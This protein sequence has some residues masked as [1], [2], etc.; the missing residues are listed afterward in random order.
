MR[1]FQNERNMYLRKLIII[2]AL[3]A[4]F[5]ILFYQVGIGVNLLLYNLLLL[6]GLAYV[7]KLALKGEVNLTLI[8]GTLLSAIFVVINGSIFAIA[9]NIISLFLLAG[10]TLFPIS[11]S[12]I[13]TSLISIVNFFYSQFA[14]L[15][16]IGELSKKSRYANAIVKVIRIL[17][18]PLIVLT[19]FILI[20]RAANPIFE[21]MLKSIFDAVENF[22]NWIFENFE[23]ALIGTIVF[24]FIIS[25]YFIL[26]K[27]NSELVKLDTGSS[28]DLTQ[29]TLSNDA[30]ITV[31]TEYKSAIVLFAMLNIL[32]LIINVIDIRWVWFNFSWD[33]EYLK[34]FVHEGTYLLILSI[35]ISLALS[36]YYFR[37]SVNFLE[38]NRNLRWLAYLWLFQNSILTVSVGIRNFWY[39]NYFSLAYLRIG[40]IFFLILTLYS[41]YTV[42]VKVR[43]KK[44]TYFL[45]SKNSLA[46]Y[47][48]LV[49]MA[50]FNWDVIIAKYNFSHS[51]SA[52]IHFNFLSELGDNALPYLDKSHDELASI[53]ANQKDVFAFR[54]Q[55][56]SSREYYDI[57]QER[58]DNFL[59]E[60]EKSKWQDWN[61]A[62]HR[63]YLKLKEQ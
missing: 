57:I 28:N 24:G 11:R 5:T 40:V 58:K 27:P 25:N 31:K 38:K 52:F 15:G 61:L 12:I 37:G 22:F 2:L 33:G 13:Y 9:I 16:L 53:D 39:I 55:Y 30:A 63:A 32:I 50:F 41:I 54:D 42:F 3:T 36:N 44:S 56:I 7:D 62:S 1:L 19:V 48:L 4:M 35:L 29:N 8:A 21:G 46:A 26:G 6:L 45:F 23:I 20:Y 60:W 47:I 18:V 10:I 59:S 49:F 43:Q 34:Q 17:I 14:F 51:K